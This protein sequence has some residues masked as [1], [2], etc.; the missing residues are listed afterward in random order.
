MRVAFAV[1]GSFNAVEEFREARKLVEPDGVFVV[2]DQIQSFYDAPI[3]AA[4]SFHAEKMSRWLKNRVRSSLLYPK[5]VVIPEEYPKWFSEIGIK[6]TT[7]S[8]EH[9]KTPFFFDG[10]TESGSSG[11]FAVKVALEDFGFD[12]VI[13]CGIPMEEGAGYSNDPN[14]IWHTA[15]RHRKGWSQVLPRIKGRV[16]STSGWT[17]KLLGHPGNEF[18]SS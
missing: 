9:I 4:V 10:Q 15:V 16:F 8:Y 17:K 5:F 13:C 1:G 12:K 6:N 2:N 7:L 14:R 3:T 18:F 11:L